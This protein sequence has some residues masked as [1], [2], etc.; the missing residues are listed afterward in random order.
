MIT[1]GIDIGSLSSNSV[2]MDENEI[3]SWVVERT[4]PDSI[5][6]AN[7]VMNGALAK[8]N[9]EFEDIEYI[10]STGYGRVV[11]PF[12]NKNITEISCHA[13]GANWFFPEVRTILDMGGQDCKAIRCNEVGKV[14]NFIMN[15][16]CAAGAG[17]HMEVVGDLIGVPLEEMGPLSLQIQDKMADVA[18]TCTVFAR[19]EIMTLLKK[20]VHKNDI[21]AG[22]CDALSVRII[23][24]LQKVE[25]EEE[26]S[27][28]GGIA[29]NIGVVK[30]IEEKV[31]MKARICFEPQIVGAVGAALF[32]RERAE[33]EAKKKGTSKA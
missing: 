22:V 9:L 30:R 4:G 15:D 14:K 18:S 17:R 20:S 7:R 12:A 10:V 33:R 21:L 24:L 28:T 5:E 8:A 26:F 11:V 31:G 6:A 32:A 25:P 13:K 23:E 29:K 19:S 3:V 2:I 27:I 16:K 1:A